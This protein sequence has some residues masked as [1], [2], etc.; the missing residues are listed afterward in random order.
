MTEE[1]YTDITRQGGV[2][3]A[4]TLPSACPMLAHHRDSVSGEG[5]RER[6]RENPT[7]STEPNGGGCVEPRKL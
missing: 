4:Y 6:E 7:V 2:M 5:Q 3:L 1:Y